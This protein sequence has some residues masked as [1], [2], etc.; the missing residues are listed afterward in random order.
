MNGIPASAMCVILIGAVH[1]GACRTTQTVEEPA[2]RRS[3]RSTM[4]C[5]SNC[6]R[7]P[8]AIRTHVRR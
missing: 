5:R 8:S 3:S 7:W 1:L 4:T 6:S 2:D